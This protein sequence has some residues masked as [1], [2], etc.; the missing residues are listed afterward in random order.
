LE[1]AQ[2]S[3]SWIGPA[4]EQ[5]EDGEAIGHLASNVVPV[6][7]DEI[8]EARVD[9]VVE[10]MVRQIEPVIWHYWKSGK[11]RPPKVDE[12]TIVGEEVTIVAKG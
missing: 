6:E 5:G 11:V 7:P 9:C 2:P 3:H 1:V 8:T 4:P 12:V 10:S